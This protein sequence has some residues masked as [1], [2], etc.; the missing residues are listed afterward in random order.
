MKNFKD[1]IFIKGK[2]DEANYDDAPITGQILDALRKSFEKYYK[3]AKR[4]IRCLNITPSNI[5]DA[6][7]DTDYFILGDEEVLN[8]IAICTKYEGMANFIKKDLRDDE[9]RGRFTTVKKGFESLEA[10]HNNPRAFSFITY[11]KD[12]VKRQTPIIFYDIKKVLNI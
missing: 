8:F 10:S 12:A 7:G 1:F 3:D 5:F 6:Q 9:L 2:L 4:K 11:S